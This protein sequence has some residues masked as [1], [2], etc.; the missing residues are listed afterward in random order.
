MPSA[1]DS[2]VNASGL[3]LSNECV[4]TEPQGEGGVIG[5]NAETAPV[6]KIP[7]TDSTERMGGRQEH[8]KIQDFFFPY[9]SATVA[10]LE[11]IVISISWLLGLHWHHYYTMLDAAVRCYS[12]C[13]HATLPFCHCLFS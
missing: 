4:T 11:L 1:P 3:K 8:L 12:L 13:F 7:Q 9:S 10:T 6:P 5:N 2:T